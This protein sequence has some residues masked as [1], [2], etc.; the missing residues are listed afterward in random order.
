MHQYYI[1]LPG[2]SIAELTVV[3][4]K[5][6]GSAC[7]FTLIKNSC[8]VNRIVD[9]SMIA[10]QLRPGDL[11]LRI[12]GLEV[13]DDCIRDVLRSCRDLGEVQVTIARSTYHA[14]RFHEQSRALGMGSPTAK[15]G[16]LF[17]CIPTCFSKPRKQ[18]RQGSSLQ[19]FNPRRQSSSN[20]DY[21]P[22]AFGS[23]ASISSTGMRPVDLRKLHK[24]GA[25]TMWKAS[26]E[27]SIR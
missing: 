14:K 16:S 1:R 23:M 20:G 26:R 7:G 25:G 18:E 13:D 3:I 8:T 6:T 19:N 9:H 22:H 27:S 11:I 15:K 5:E 4:N 2:M 24:E 17:S 21:S 12:N 10:D